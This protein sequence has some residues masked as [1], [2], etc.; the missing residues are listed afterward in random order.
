MNQEFEQR[1]NQIILDQ[2]VLPSEAAE[3][4]QKQLADEEVKKK[5]NGD[6]STDSDSSDGT[7]E[8]IDKPQFP[9]T[10]WQKEQ[11]EATP[12]WEEDILNTRGTAKDQEEADALNLEYEGLIG[13]YNQRLGEQFTKLSTLMFSSEDPE[14]LM[15]TF[16]QETGFALDDE[17]RASLYESTERRKQREEEFQ[18]GLRE[19]ED[20]AQES[21]TYQPVL[22]YLEANGVSEEK[23]D[24]A[25]ARWTQSRELETTINDLFE[26]S[27]SPEAFNEGIDAVN[28]SDEDKEEF[29]QRFL[30]A[31]NEQGEDLYNS[32]SQRGLDNLREIQRLRRELKKIQNNEDLNLIERDRK[33]T[34]IEQKIK[35]LQDLADNKG[36][37]MDA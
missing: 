15:N 22:D 10:Q 12:E 28:I 27:V 32:I 23:R 34:I 25:Y 16:E 3:I 8:Y 37:I 33:S 4:A 36:E 2:N 19:A 14:S 6:E 35:D 21:G 29:K 17:T 1:V 9:L 18:Q 13:E 26:G 30:N 11:L 31:F 5:E 7:F 20:L 24:E